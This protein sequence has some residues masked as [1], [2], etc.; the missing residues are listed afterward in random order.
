MVVAVLEKEVILSA[1]AAC[2][3]QRVPRA[4]QVS[5]DTEALMDAVSAPT[6]GSKMRLREWRFF[7]LFMKCVLCFFVWLCYE[8]LK[9]ESDF[10]QKGQT[11][12]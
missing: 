4:P 8:Q 10:V 3:D 11:V 6:S 9:Y 12:L 7:L 5:I 2:A 1:T